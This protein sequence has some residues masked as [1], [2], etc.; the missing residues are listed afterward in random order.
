MSMMAAQSQFC[1]TLGCSAKVQR[2][3]VHRTCSEFSG[4]TPF[5]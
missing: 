1:H 3:M 5:L 4:G 2:G